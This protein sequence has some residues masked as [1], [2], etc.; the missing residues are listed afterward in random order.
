MMP[1]NTTDWT[2]K[3]VKQSMKL[4]NPCVYFKFPTASLSV[5]L[6]YLSGRLY[7]EV[8]GPGLIYGVRMDV[9]PTG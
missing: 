5:M 1:Y 8:R 6:G 9:S 7:D 4:V 3:E 2:P